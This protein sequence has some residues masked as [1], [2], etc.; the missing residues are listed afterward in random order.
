MITHASCAAWR[1]FIASLPGSAHRFDLQCRVRRLG[2][3]IAPGDTW[4]CG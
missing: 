1:Y 4:L 2:L 3:M